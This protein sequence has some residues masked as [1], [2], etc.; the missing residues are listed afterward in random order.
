MNPPRA[1][2][3]LLLALGLALGPALALTPAASAVD[4][5]P[6]GALVGHDV[7]WPQCPHGMPLPRPGAFVI[8]GLTDGTALHRNPCLRTQLAWGVG[9][10][11][12][13]A[14]YTMV[15]P[16]TRAELARDQDG[17]LH[18][19][20]SRGSN[21][22]VCAFGNAGAAEA[23]DALRTLASTGWETDLLWAD[24]ELRSTQ[25]W[26]SGQRRANR[27]LLAAF[28][29]TLRKA[30]VR[31]GYYSTSFQWQRITGGW[32]PPAGSPEWYAIGTGGVPALRAGC[33]HS[34]AGGPTAITQSVW[35][36][37]DVDLVCPGGQ[38][39]VEAMSLHPAATAS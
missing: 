23:L 34:F 5:R 32:S 25:P 11:R 20:T 9:S 28:D 27:A 26:L 19:C 18:T 2:R 22:V 31:A 30:G 12:S 4:H 13:L 8:I 21:R 15:N 17:P 39:V 33:T 35:G 16:P 24:V 7:S 14:A 3:S 29:A 37:H 1:L 6:V 10:H 36:Q 38:S